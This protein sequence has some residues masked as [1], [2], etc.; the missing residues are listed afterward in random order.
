MPPK[1][2]LSQATFDESVAT[3]IEDFGMEPEEAVASAVEEFT[4]QGYDVSGIIQSASGG[5]VRE[6]PIAVA[7]INVEQASTS[8][9]PAALETL[10]TAVKDENAQGFAVA[11]QAKTMRLLLKRTEALVSESASSPIFVAMLEVIKHLLQSAELRDDFSEAQ[12]PELMCQLLATGC[13][14]VDPGAESSPDVST[15]WALVGAAAATAA[16]ASFKEEE[17]KCR[18]VDLGGVASA[19]THLRRHATQLPPDTLADLVGLVKAVLTPDDDRPMTSKAFQHARLLWSD[20]QAVPVMMAALKA[21]L[22]ATQQQGASGGATEACVCVL[23]A[24]R[25]LAANDDICKELTDMG[26]VTACLDVLKGPLV[27]NPEVCT[28]VLGCLR[29]LAGSDSVKVSIAEQGGINLVLRT[30]M[31]HPGSENVCEGVLGL[32]T[33]ITLR[34]PNLA[35]KAAE[36]G[37]LDAVL[38]VLSAHSSWASACRQ[39]A[40]MV[41]NMVVRS[42]TVRVLA[43]EKGLEA[44]LRQAKAVHNKNRDLKDAASAALR[45]LGLDNYND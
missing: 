25:G 32:L 14:D 37:A 12:G 19:L 5:N 20:L 27:A 1:P 31:V 10:L 13:C 22:E 11:H 39:A 34:M 24:V 30:M 9:V 29:Q 41:R 3:N 8:D 18:F 36:A 21:A 4:T 26:G 2:K 44:L 17:T 42:P 43:L 15:T 35:E 38:E 7:A 23:K 16:A 45:D 33:A 6:H 40:M 28:A